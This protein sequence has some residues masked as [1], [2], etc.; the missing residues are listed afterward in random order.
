MEKH[1]LKSLT[2]YI[3]LI[4]EIKRCDISHEVVQFLKN[5][6]TIKFT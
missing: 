1:Q 4:S 5:D 3:A 6:L 2:N